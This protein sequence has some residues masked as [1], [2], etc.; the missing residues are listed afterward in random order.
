MVNVS[1]IP[2]KLY[3]WNRS[4]PECSSSIINVEF[5]VNQ[6]RVRYNSHSHMQPITVASRSVP[7]AVAVVGKN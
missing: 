6:L 1:I 2:F 5:G 4:I 3:F 7:G